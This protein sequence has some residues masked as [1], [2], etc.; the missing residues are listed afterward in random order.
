MR[1]RL[2]TLLIASLAIAAAACLAAAYRFASHGIPVHDYLCIGLAGAA[3]ALAA[4]LLVGAFWNW[5]RL[6]PKSQAE[7]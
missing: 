4:A 3:V 7:R 2:R 1:Y 6:P 5:R